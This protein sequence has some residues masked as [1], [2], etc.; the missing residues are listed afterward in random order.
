MTHSQK[1]TSQ[2]LFEALAKEVWKL[3]DLPGDPITP[4]LTDIQDMAIATPEPMNDVAITSTGATY[5]V[6]TTKGVIH[7]TVRVTGGIVIQSQEVIGDS[8]SD[9]DPLPSLPFVDRR[10]LA[11]VLSCISRHIIRTAGEPSIDQVEWNAHALG[12]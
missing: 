12:T 11:K 5:K 8:A 7:G 4:T 2:A 3:D 1:S 10:D 9:W 6:I